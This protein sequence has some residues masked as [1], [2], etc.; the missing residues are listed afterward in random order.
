MLRYGGNFQDI[1]IEFVLTLIR[2]YGYILLYMLRYGGNFQD[3]GI[4]F[5]LTLIRL[6]GYILLYMYI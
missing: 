4:E 6:Y 2:L 3:I 5:V 1:G